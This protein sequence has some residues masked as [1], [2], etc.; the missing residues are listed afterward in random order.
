MLGLRAGTGQNMLE[1][2]G[3]GQNN[4]VYSSFFPT[5]NIYFLSKLT[6]LLTLVAWWGWDLTSE[7]AS[8]EC[9]NEV[10]DA[11]DLSPAESSIYTSRGGPLVLPE[12]LDTAHHMSYGVMMV[13]YLPRH[14]GLGEV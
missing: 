5:T 14:S 7:S 8:E 9:S 12:T 10:D 4:L 11:G 13:R 3:N 2:G 6:P 1:T